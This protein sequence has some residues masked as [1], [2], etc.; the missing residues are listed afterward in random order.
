MNKYNNYFITT[1]NYL[2][3]SCRY[4]ILSLNIID[5]DICCY[6]YR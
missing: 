1:N 2:D 4:Y 6:Y 3:I 5:Q